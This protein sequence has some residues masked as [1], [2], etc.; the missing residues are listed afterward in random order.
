MINWI[1]AKKFVP[2][3]VVEHGQRTMPWVLLYSRWTDPCFRVGYYEHNCTRDHGW[4]NDMGCDVDDVECWAKLEPPDGWE[5]VPDA[6]P[7]KAI[8]LEAS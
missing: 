2:G 5:F 8:E 1:S 4:H 6:I 7:L 3:P